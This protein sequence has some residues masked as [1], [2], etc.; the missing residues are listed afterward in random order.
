MRRPNPMRQQGFGLLA[1]V[2]LSAI[3]AFTM[4]VGYAGVMT[5]REANALP[6][7]QE[8]YVRDSVEAIREAWR[9][10]ALT[11]DAF[12]LG[13]TT[14]AQ[15]ILKASGVQLRYGAQVVL[16]NVV[17]VDAEGI[18]FRSVL[19]Y[20][21]VETDETSPPD[22][23]A[24]QSTGSFVSCPSPSDECSKR[25]Y[26]VFS[27]ADLERALSK[28]TRLRLTRVAEK[29][30]SYFKARMLQD[31]ERNVSVNYFHK[32]F[33][34][35]EVME[36]DLGCMD[37]YQPLV[38]LDSGTSLSRTRLAVNLALTDEELFTAWGRP[39]EASNLQDS[40]TTDSPYTMTFRAPNQAG[41]FYT[42]KAV[43]L[44]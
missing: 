16:S 8:R 39:I 2:M 12:S 6:A 43:Q 30:Q 17:K 34:A 24:F 14:T 23:S 37:T 11:W 9:S 4:V 29:A 35:C 13:N 20:L 7:K 18:A 36:M 15:D 38:S 40:E 32:P 19:F 21:P 1:F 27:S 28:E 3:V 10:N 44:Y 26:Q 42:V 5:R 22:I 41:G 33:G 25:V 31:P